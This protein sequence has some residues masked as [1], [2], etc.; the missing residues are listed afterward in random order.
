MILPLSHQEQSS[1]N[2]HKKSKTRLKS[3]VLR[4][5][6]VQLGHIWVKKNKKNNSG[7]VS[8]WFK[9]IKAHKKISIE[10]YLDQNLMI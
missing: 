1:G 6:K 7:N 8:K 10:K 3:M 9:K 2:K 5:L 4:P